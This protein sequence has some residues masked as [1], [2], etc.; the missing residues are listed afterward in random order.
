V[1]KPNSSFVFFARLRSELASLG[2]LRT[3]CHDGIA[4]GKRTG[5]G[6]E[7]FEADPQKL[8]N[9]LLAQIR[10]AKP[11]GDR[12]RASVVGPLPGGLETDRAKAVDEVVER[13]RG[14]LFARA[15]GVK[16]IN[17]CSVRAQPQR[18]PDSPAVSDANVR[19]GAVADADL[20]E[21][22]LRPLDELLDEAQRVVG[23]LRDPILARSLLAAYPARRPGDV[24][25]SF[26]V[27]AERT[28]GVARYKQQEARALST[29]TGAA[30]IRERRLSKLSTK[31]GHRQGLS[32]LSAEDPRVSVALYS[33][34]EVAQ[35]VGLPYS[36]L[37]GW[38]N[39]G[40]EREPLVTS[41][42]RKGYEASMP[43]IGLAEAFVLQAARQAGVPRTRIR[44]GVEAVRRELGLAHALAS[45]LLYTDGTELLVKYAVDDGDLEV[46][47][48]RQR[49]LTE[50]V[51]HQ[52]QLITY[53]GDG[54]VARLELAGYGP[55]QVIVDPGVAFGYPVVKGAGARVKDV[56]DRFWAGEGLRAIAHDFDLTEDAVEAIVRAQTRPTS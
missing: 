35:Y 33:V 20:A 27:A 53:A 17:H 13:D 49:Q 39:P 38:V 41:V 15:V 37:Q 11:E 22:L 14:L 32:G 5:S 34:S 24:E 52:L 19:L 12:I 9:G 21:V 40:A 56:L 44:P 23:S 26:A 55:A 43:F 48:T 25:A 45:K 8:L 7:D 54:Y 16:E 36:T 29:N 3:D 30:R 31:A 46:A 2:F 6:F 10:K 51:K 47:R 28:F 42:P 4:L 50:T 18:R 1:R